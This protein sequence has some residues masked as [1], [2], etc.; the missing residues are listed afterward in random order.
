ML[1]DCERVFLRAHVAKEAFKGMC[2]VHARTD[3][4]DDANKSMSNMLLTTAK[5]LNTLA[6]NDARCMSEF[7]RSEITTVDRYLMVAYRVLFPFLLKL[8]KTQRLSHGAFLTFTHD[9]SCGEPKG[10]LVPFIK[11]ISLQIML[12]KS[13]YSA[14]M[15]L[16][17]LHSL[18]NEV[19]RR[20]SF[21]SFMTAFVEAYVHIYKKQ[22]LHGI[23]EFKAEACKSLTPFVYTFQFHQSRH[24][25][26]DDMRDHLTG[27]RVHPC[28][29][30][31]GSLLSEYM[32]CGEYQTSMAIM[33]IGKTVETHPAVPVLVSAFLD[34]HPRYPF[35]KSF[36][37]Q[38][39]E[40]DGGDW[41]EVKQREYVSVQTHAHN[42]IPIEEVSLGTWFA[43]IKG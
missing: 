35:G 10:P 14:S 9:I 41:R 38:V 31:L 15:E 36:W 21:R 8:A 7:T 4:M 37:D 6:A 19:I 20:S 23:D 13:V 24:V 3:E 40:N 18:S 25:F 39:K 43:R 11:D 1:A 2:E 30:C 33:A 32:H 12:N 26:F 16:C 29:E 17:L 5:F 28:P 42:H 27:I 22:P 34:C